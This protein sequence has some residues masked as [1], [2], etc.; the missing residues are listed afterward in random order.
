LDSPSI[1]QV[2][3]TF[4]SKPEADR[5]AQLSALNQ[6]VG[7]IARLRQE[8]AQLDGATTDTK[9]RL[10][11][12]SILTT[13]VA[14]ERTTALALLRDVKNQDVGIPQ[15]VVLYNEAV[16]NGDLQSADILTKRAVEI[17]EVTDYEH[18][19]ALRQRGQYLFTAARPDEARIFFEQSINAFQP[20]PATAAARSYV[21]MNLILGELYA[22][23]C[24]RVPDEVRR[25]GTLLAQPL[26]TPEQRSSMIDTL[27]PQYDVFR[28]QRCSTLPPLTT[29]PG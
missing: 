21:L 16:N 19:E 23:D 27:R 1:A 3:E 22:G 18:S 28:S 11:L 24:E 8:F 2:R 6:S 7:S 20:V 25:F 29:L 10:A 9:Q 17:K 14:N 13:R 12:E 5:I 26:V 4:L 15:L